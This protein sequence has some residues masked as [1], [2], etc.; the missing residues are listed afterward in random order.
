MAKSQ[1]SSRH[2]ERRLSISCEIVEYSV[3]SVIAAM[4]NHSGNAFFS[5]CFTL[6]NRTL[7]TTFRDPILN[8]ARFFEHVIVG[9]LIIMLYSNGIGNESGCFNTESSNE[10]LATISMD[11]IRNIQTVVFQNLGFIF[12]SMIFL[13]YAS[14]MPVV[15]V[16]PTEMSVFLRE[17]TNGWY[18]CLS[19]FTA[20]TIA[21]IPFLL[22]FTLIYASMIYYFTG[23][24]NDSWRFGAFIGVAMLV[25][26]IGQSI[27][28]VF[29]TLCV[30]NL[31]AASF[32]A[33][34]VPLPFAL[35]SG[36]FIRVELIPSYLKIFTYISSIRYVIELLVIIIYGFDRCGYSSI[37]E[38]KESINGVIIKF[39]NYLTKLDLSYTS[40]RPILY[41]LAVDKN[42][43]LN[44]ISSFDVHF[45]NFTLPEFNL[46]GFDE[47]KSFALQELNLNDDNLWFHTWI[48]V[49]TGE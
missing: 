8:Y 12:F 7:K 33:P 49:S 41:A 3:P 36:F 34:L 39:F 11:K 1:N 5:H 47:N 40:A 43:S 19:Y 22:L 6:V 10:S 14:M 17:R 45:E 42:L 31:R 23:Q 20:K 27:G 24:I 13:L 46:L 16:F 38:D 30:K 35:F 37:I 2:E 28:L 15:L 9:V 25:A 44:E 21:D 29:G 18:S 48:L 32:L 4:R 26:L